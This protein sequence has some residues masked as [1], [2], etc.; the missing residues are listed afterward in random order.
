MRDTGGK[1]VC[2]SESD[3]PSWD[4]VTPKGKSMC[5][6]LCH[7]LISF[8]FL[9]A[10]WCC[11]KDMLYVHDPGSGTDHESA[12]RGKDR[13]PQIQGGTDAW[14]VRHSP[15]RHRGGFTS[16]GKWEET[17]L[18]AFIAYTYVFVL[19][20]VHYAHVQRSKTMLRNMLAYGT[21]TTD[22]LSVCCHG[23]DQMH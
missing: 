22:D 17:K 2:E 9:F 5:T 7:L 6:M 15:T 1:E 3:P 8:F 18:R 14:P 4:A 13:E 11:Y 12:M 23:S 10:V 21:H 20:P 16:L 19:V